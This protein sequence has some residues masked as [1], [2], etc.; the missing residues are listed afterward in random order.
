MTC[1]SF[2]LTYLMCSIWCV[3]INVYMQMICSLHKT[4]VKQ[5]DSVG[6]L[7]QCTFVL[8]VEWAFDGGFLF[9]KINKSQQQFCEHWPVI[10]QHT[11]CRRMAGAVGQVQCSDL[12]HQVQVTA[13]NPLLAL[14]HPARQKHTDQPW[15]IIWLL[16]LFY[17]YQGVKRLHVK[18]FH[19]SITK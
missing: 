4:W 3:L 15:Y 12:T 19:N 6:S 17:Q 8:F 16:L 7:L 5:L 1:L 10:S 9:W 14:G 11:D 18:V 2:C 13:A